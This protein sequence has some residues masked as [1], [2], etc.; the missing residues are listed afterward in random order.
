M[1]MEMRG[2]GCRDAGCGVE[3]I[4]MY[5]QVWPVKERRNSFVEAEVAS[6]NCLFLEAEVILPS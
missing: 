2:F 6:R 3:G 5:T 1:A 4:R